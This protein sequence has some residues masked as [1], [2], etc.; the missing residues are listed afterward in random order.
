MSS[1]HTSYAHTDT[2]GQNFH[3]NCARASPNITASS[4]TDQAEIIMGM[5]FCRPTHHTE[6]I[7]RN[8]EKNTFAPFTL[9]SI[10][11]LHLKFVTN[12]VFKSTFP[13]HGS[14]I[15]PTIL[16]VSCEYYSLAFLFVFQVLVNYLHHP[17]VTFYDLCL[18]C[19]SS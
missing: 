18:F 15:Y 5:I 14:L 7:G 19:T 9:E 17:T 4:T 12:C 3:V 1:S 16:N 6:E 2:N 13:A 8:T 10:I 11:Q